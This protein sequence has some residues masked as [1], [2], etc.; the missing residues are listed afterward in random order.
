MTRYLRIYWLLIKFSAILETTYRLNFLVECIVEIGYF[1]ITIVGLNILY[2]NVRSLAGWNYS[3]MLVLV[4]LNMI[5]SEILLGLSYI[6]NLRRLPAQ[7]ANGDLDLVLTKPINSQFAASLWRPYFA[8]IPSVLT[9]LI[10]IKIGFNAGGFILNPLYLI[11]FILIF[12]SGLVIA[13]SF[14][15]IC[16]TLTFWW[17]NASPLPDLAQEIVLMSGRPYQI[18]EGFWKYLFLLLIPLA[19]MTTFPAQI[20]MGELHWWWVPT[21]II[22]AAIFLKCSNLFWNFGLK[23][24]SSASS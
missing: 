15:V 12:V 11:P 18:F 20:L 5:F 14:S 6:Y 4:G 13:Y 21:S 17:T 9:G 19:F 23:H 7:V 8:L 2:A 24:Y 10:V 22:L 16:C 1:I 3:Q